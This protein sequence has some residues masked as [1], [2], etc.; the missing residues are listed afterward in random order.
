[1]INHLLQTPLEYFTFFDIREVIVKKKR[2]L[3]RDQKG[4]EGRFD[5]SWEHK[6]HIKKKKYMLLVFIRTQI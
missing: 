4:G 1:M 5:K 2:S 6:D 3:S